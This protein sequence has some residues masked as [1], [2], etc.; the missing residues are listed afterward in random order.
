MN[1]DIQKTNTEPKLELIDY[2][3]PIQDNI[4]NLNEFITVQISRKQILAVGC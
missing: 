3:E 1:T 4:N 2:I